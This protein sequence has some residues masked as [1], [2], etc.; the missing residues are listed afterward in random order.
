MPDMTPT[1]TLSDRL[2]DGA[3]MLGNLW[4]RGKRCERGWSL[5]AADILATVSPLVFSGCTCAKPSE[6]CKARWLWIAL[7]LENRQEIFD[8]PAGLVDTMTASQ[9][10]ATGL[11]ATVESEKAGTLR[12]GSKGVISAAHLRKLADDPE[13][14]ISIFS[15]T[16]TFTK[17]RVE[18]VVEPPPPEKV[19]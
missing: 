6:F 7:A 5:G 4:R 17:A 18:G 8:G 13:S 14:A 9:W 19:A 11:T 12:I 15:L 3:R 16:R 10:D 2:L 1:K